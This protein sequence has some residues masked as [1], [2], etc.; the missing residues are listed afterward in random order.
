M[1]QLLS[2]WRSREPRE[3]VLLSVFGVLF[4]LAVYYLLIAAPLLAYATRAERNYD[5]SLANASAL[6]RQV[7]IIE[8]AADSPTLKSDLLSLQQSAD[9]AGLSGLQQVQERGGA[10]RLSINDANAAQLMPWLA[11]LPS[12]TGASVLSFQIQRSSAGRVSA[13]ITVQT[14]R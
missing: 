9:N 6:L 14:Q 10:V 7:A 8:K 13:A 5:R 11:R 1:N 4:A 3:Q 2:W 12:E